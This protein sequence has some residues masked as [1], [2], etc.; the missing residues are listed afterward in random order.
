MS[1]RLTLG[2][3]G[4]RLALVQTEGVAEALRAAFPDLEVRVEIIH[5]RG[6]KILDAP[7]AQ[8][9]GK[10]LFTRELELA[11]LDGR[12]DAAVHSLKDVPTQLPPGL[13]LGAVPRR[14]SPFDAMV[15]PNCRSLHDLP[16]GARV[17]TSSLRRRAQLLA[18]RRDLE[19][20][21]LRG[22]IDTRLRK[23]SGGEVHA[24]VLAKAGLLRLGRADVI[25]C[26]L[27][28]STIVPAPGQGA[29]GL[30]VREGDDSVLR[31]L[32][33]L[34]DP[35]ATAETAAER[36]CLAA[37]EGGCQVPIGAL[38]QLAGERL[39]LTACVCSL[40][41]GHVLRTTVEGH[42]DRASEAGERAARDLI[43]KGAGELIA[44]IR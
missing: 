5:T 20:V 2:T 9:G 17:G 41:G 30:E 7:L 28:V 29:L 27:P 39:L 12:I 31:L 21:N 4:S 24:A 26:E 18:I 16:R 25:A 36:A 6:D 34:A 1:A 3:R 40:D 23:V 33:S 8:I 10:G 15:A 14:E 43:V 32:A 38:A 42:P 22:N 35:R 19:V 37:L 11:L 13:A 44:A